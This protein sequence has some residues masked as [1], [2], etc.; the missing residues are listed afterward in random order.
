MK[1]LS[2]ILLTGALVLGPSL[3]KAEEE[4]I[5]QNV[6][7]TAPVAQEVSTEPGVAIVTMKLFNKGEIDTLSKV[8]SPIADEVTLIE[9]QRGY[10]NSNRLTLPSKQTVFLKTTD[11]HFRLTGIDKK[12]EVNDTVPLDLDFTDNQKVRV[13]AKVIK[14]IKTDPVVIN[15]TTIKVEP[16]S[17]TIKVQPAAPTVVVDPAPA[18]V[19][20]PRSTT[21]IKVE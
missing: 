17:P 14:A 20:E 8:S 1:K 13:N 7:I 9:P 10:V 5:A 3:A 4:F 2:L 12:L 16:A 21:T 19:V 18:V 6:V 11:T 15:Q